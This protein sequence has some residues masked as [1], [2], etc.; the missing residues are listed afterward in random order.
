MKA[1]SQLF[2]DEGLLAIKRDS[3]QGINL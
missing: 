2:K 1:N 3:E